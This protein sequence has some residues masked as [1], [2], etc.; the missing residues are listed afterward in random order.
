MVALVD[1]ELEIAAAWSFAK[2]IDIWKSKHEKA[3]F[4]Q[5]LK[6]KNQNVEFRYLD[7]VQICEGADFFKVLKCIAEG[8]LY[9]DPAVKAEKWQLPGMKVKKRNQFRIAMRSISDLY[10]TSKLVDV[11]QSH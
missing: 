4:V 1:E 7:Q 5:A 9:L 2:L 6:R 8:K 3:V 10:R 11:T